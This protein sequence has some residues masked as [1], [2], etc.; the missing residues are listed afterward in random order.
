MKILASYPFTIILGLGLSIS[1]ALMV[2]VEHFSVIVENNIEK[3]STFE[4][5][6]NFNMLESKIDSINEQAQAIGVRTYTKNEAID[7]VIKY[8]DYLLTKY[9]AQVGSDRPIDSGDV[10]RLKVTFS[11]NFKSAGEFVKTLDQMLKMTSPIVLIS[12][13]SFVQ[14]GKEQNVTLY[15]IQVEGEIIQPYVSEGK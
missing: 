8:A 3:I 4:R 15:K 10:L 12:R 13:L 5:N 11:V 2:A 1:I 9:S 7:V 6:T 14:E